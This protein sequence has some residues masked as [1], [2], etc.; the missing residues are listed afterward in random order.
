MSLYLAALFLIGAAGSVFAQEDQTKTNTPPPKVL[1]VFREFLKPGKNG[2]MHE[3]SESVFV[4][5]LRRAKWP[6]HYLSVDSLS[7]KT[8]SLFLTGYESFEA[9]EKD[10]QATRSNSALS[11]A[12]DRATIADGDLLSETDSSAWVFNADHSLNPEVDVRH[13]RYI[14]IE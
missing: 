12:L 10:V 13:M 2:S 5:A 14:D 9:W 4:Q 6:T 8:R 3:K 1:A 7:G 11:A